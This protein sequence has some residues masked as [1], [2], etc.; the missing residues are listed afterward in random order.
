MFAVHRLWD[1]E[2]TVTAEHARRPY[3]AYATIMGLLAGRIAVAASSF[4]AAAASA[5]GSRRPRN[6]ASACTAL[7][8]ML[9]WTLAAAGIN[10]VLQA[11]F[12]A[13]TRKANELEQDAGR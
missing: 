11:G 7:G 2:T 13:L 5:L 4:C 6:D 10:D 8:R 1:Q 12:A 3:E 9:T